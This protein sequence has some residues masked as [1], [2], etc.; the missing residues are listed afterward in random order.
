MDKWLFVQLSSAGRL[1]HPPVP[2]VS[3]TEPCL[4]SPQSVAYCVSA[5]N[6]RSLSILELGLCNGESLAVFQSSPSSKGSI[7][8][9]EHLGVQRFGVRGVAHESLGHTNYFNLYLSHTF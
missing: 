2:L 9:G 7:W 1:R 3:H 8:E 4:F 6:N 5:E